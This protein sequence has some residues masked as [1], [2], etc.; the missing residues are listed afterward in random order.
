MKLLVIAAF[1]VSSCLPLAVGVTPVAAAT[2]TYD[3]TL[4]VP[5]NVTSGGFA[6]TGS[7]TLTVNTG[8]G[9]DTVTGITGTVTNTSNNAVDPI[10]MLAPTGTLNNNDNLVFPIGSTF[11]GPPVTTSTTP[12][13]S[14]SNLDTHGLAFVIATGPTTTAT[15]AVFGFNVPNGTAPPPNSNPYG[16]F[17]P[18]G[19]GVGQFT[20]TPTPL[21]A[22]LPLFATGLGTIGLLG[23]HRRRKACRVAA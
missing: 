3:W 20:L 14:I 17:S 11:V 8:T 21:P 6:F 13:V 10:T 9:S 2:V 22:A 12:Y 1:S 23:W 4:G 15:I 5:S 18:G 19:F 7:G 16:E